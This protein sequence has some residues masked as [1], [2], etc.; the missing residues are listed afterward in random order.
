MRHRQL[1]LTFF[2]VLASDRIFFSHAFQSVANRIPP[3]KPTLLSSQHVQFNARGENH[4]IS[5]ACKYHNQKSKLTGPSTSTTSLSLLFQPS[6]GISPTDAWGNWAVLTGTATISQVLGKTTRIGKLLGPP[7]TAMALT[8]GL[9]SIGILHPGGT[10]AATALQLLSLQL[11]TPLILLGADLRDCVARCGPLLLSFMVAAMATLIACLV[12]WRLTGCLLQSALGPRDG[13]AIAAALMAKNIGGGINYVAVCRS[14]N[15]SPVA[16]AAGLCVDNIFALLY[17]PVTSA[18]G[19]GR[20]DVSV[21]TSSRQRQLP[22]DD[23]PSSSSNDSFSIQGVST[24]LFLSSLL[25]WM[26]EKVGGKSGALPCCTIL[27]VLVASLAPAN[28][29]KPVQEPA[30]VLGTT[31]LYLFFATAGAPGIAV[32]ES[33]RASLIP[34]SL[35]LTLL[36][37]LHGAIL[38]LLHKL[39]PRRASFLPQRLLVASS[40]AI[41]GPA[42]AV[43]LAQAQGWESLEV[44]SLL[45]GNIGYAIATFCGLAYYAFFSG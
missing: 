14:L 10:P 6:W 1:L 4:P 45:V 32:A 33:V 22:K 42:T 25:L 9:A 37:S 11:A 35:F 31:C 38:W 39:F 43:A 7:V 40:A 20:A 34:L 44:P 36:Y 3:Q 13:L 8:F 2:L 15:A 12:G 41:G 26:G 17:F 29:M 27:T 21:L 28:V 18:L 5:S 19:A 24:A 23:N 30:H 16:I